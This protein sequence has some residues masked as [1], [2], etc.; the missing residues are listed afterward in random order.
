MSSEERPV[1][2]VRLDL[3]ALQEAAERF[4]DTDKSNFVNEDDSIR[5]ELIGMR[6]FAKPL[7][8]IAAADDQMFLLL[9]KEDVLHPEY[10]L[11]DEWLPG[12]KSVIS[13]AVSIT[14]DVKATNALDMSWPSDE[15][16]HARIEGQ[17][18]VIALCDMIADLLQN[19]GYSAVI[20]QKDNRWKEIVPFRTSWSERHAGFI[21]GLGTFGISKG[22]ITDHGAAVRLGS[23]I[24]DCPLTPTSRP[25]SEIYEY[26]VSCGMCQ[27]NCPVNA[28]DTSRGN[29]L[30]KD[31]PTCMGFMRTVRAKP[32]ECKS[33]RIHF[34]CGKCQVATPCESSAPG[35][36]A[37]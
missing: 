25:Y 34:G 21:A 8:R 37:V 1:S 32:P 16:M 19:E 28:I 3:S 2:E 33:G 35:K 10:L 31:H 24:T 5:P 4:L 20:P 27:T 26:C 18:T 30:A 17:D 36:K 29:H 22:L 12:A 13:F 14:Q 11:P 7:V 23:I 9:K 6:M 15:W